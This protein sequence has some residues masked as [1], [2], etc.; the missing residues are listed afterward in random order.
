MVRQQPSFVVEDGWTLGEA[1]RDIN[2]H[3]IGALLASGASADDEKHFFDPGGGYGP[4]APLFLAVIWGY[5]R[6]VA[7]LLEFDADPEWQHPLYGSTALHM[8]AKAGLAA[9]TTQLLEKRAK[10][11]SIDRDGCTPLI[12]ATLYGHTSCVQ[13]LLKH[14]ANAS[15]VSH[16]LGTALKVAEREGYSSDLGGLREPFLTLAKMLRHAERLQRVDLPHTATEAEVEA[17]ERIAEGQAAATRDEWGA[18]IRCYELAASLTPEDELLPSK[19]KIE[20]LQ[21]YAKV[22]HLKQL[23]LG[24]L[25]SI[26]AAA[27]ASCLEDG[28]V[29]LQAKNWNIEQALDLMLH[30]PES[31]PEP[32]PEIQDKKKKKKIKQRSASQSKKKPNATQS[33]KVKSSKRSKKTKDKGCRAEDQ[34]SEAVPISAPF[35]PFQLPVL[36]QVRGTPHHEEESD[37]NDDDV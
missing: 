10:P 37:D 36:T 31:E 21:Q 20:P 32:E 11:N 7:E 14:K 16:G 33:G 13:L 24:H 19:R 1:V 12:T 3:R 22:H 34:K 35:Q 23:Y 18:A 4:C 26:T 30:P 25:T 6:I 27:L 17:A 29:A 15:I 28:R 9:V 2:E 8:A 5:Q